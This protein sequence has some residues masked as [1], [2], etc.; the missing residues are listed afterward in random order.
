[1]MDIGYEPA[2]GDAVV[3][4]S[5][6]VAGANGSL[7]VAM[8]NIASA[9]RSKN[10]ANTFNLELQEIYVEMLLVQKEQLQRIVGMK[11]KVDDLV[12]GQLDFF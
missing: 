2:R 3:G 12:S 1:M 11:E 9:R 8:V 5:N 6:A 10:T 4:V 7:G